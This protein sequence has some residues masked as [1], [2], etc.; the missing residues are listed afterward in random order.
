MKGI[1]PAYVMT[2]GRGP[3]AFLS[4]RT[5]PFSAHRLAC[6]PEALGSSRSD[7]VQRDGRKERED[8][9]HGQQGAVVPG[10][11]E[12]HADGHFQDADQR[13]LRA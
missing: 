1:T 12:E 5:L 7:Y 6:Y 2:Q 9:E 3:A 13:G 8:S 10:L 11:Q 4:S